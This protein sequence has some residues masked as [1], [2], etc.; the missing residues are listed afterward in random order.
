M[1]VL[2]AI[3]PNP[4]D[5]RALADGP[6]AVVDGELVVPALLECGVP[7]CRRC[8]DSWVGLASDGCTATAMVVDRPGVTRHDVVR[9]L[10][11]WLDRTGIVDTVVQAAATGDYCVDGAIVDDPVTAVADLVGLHLAAIVEACDL[12]RDGSVV[13]RHGDRVTSGDVERAA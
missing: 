2:I 1:R 4:S 10:H 3:S 8:A 7:A 5:P 12:F 9:A 13:V 6:P 11:D